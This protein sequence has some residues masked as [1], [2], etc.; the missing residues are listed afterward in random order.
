MLHFSSSLFELLY[1]SIKHRL[2][3]FHI[4]KFLL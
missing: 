4:I 1:I 2:Y 3:L